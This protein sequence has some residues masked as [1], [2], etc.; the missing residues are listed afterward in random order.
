MNVVE[1][2]RRAAY[3]GRKRA[4]LGQTPSG[5]LNRSTPPPRR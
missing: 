1:S 5:Q 3:Y 4:F 2:E